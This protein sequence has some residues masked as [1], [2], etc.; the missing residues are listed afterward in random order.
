MIGT[1]EAGTGKQ[2][3]ISLAKPIR[4]IKYLLHNNYIK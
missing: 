3:C 2:M 4:L 1:E